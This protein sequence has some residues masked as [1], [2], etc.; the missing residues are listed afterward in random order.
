MKVVTLPV[1][2]VTLRYLTY[3]HGPGPIRPHWSSA[4]AGLLRVGGRPGEQPYAGASQILTHTIAVEVDTSAAARLERYAE[5][6]GWA[7]H[8][9]VNE[10]MCQWTRAHVRK[11]GTVAG[12]LRDFYAAHGMDQDDLLD[13]SSYKRMQR[14]VKRVKRHDPMSWPPSICHAAVRRACGS[15]SMS[16]RASPLA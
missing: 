3:T 2:R 13:E 5:H 8:N 7:A 9:Y 12:G 6:V 16:A 11:G 15:A 10:V 14:F 4:L 1:S